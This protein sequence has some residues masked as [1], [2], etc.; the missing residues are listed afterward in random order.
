[1]LLK[2]RVVMGDGFGDELG[3]HGTDQNDYKN[4][5]ES[6]SVSPE[7]HCNL[8]ILVLKSQIS[9]NSGFGQAILMPIQHDTG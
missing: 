3:E 9:P 4:E 2:I 7:D 5:N 1:M 6:A 8:H